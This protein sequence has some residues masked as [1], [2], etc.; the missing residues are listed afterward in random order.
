MHDEPILKA[1]SANRRYALRNDH[2]DLSAP[3]E[4]GLAVVTCM[5]ARIDPLT[6]MG[7]QLGD[8]HVI[9]NAGSVVTEDVLRSLVVSHH[10]LGTRHVMVIGHTDCGMATFNG[11]DFADE[12]TAASGVRADDIK[13][14][15]TFGHVQSHVRRQV[16]RVLDHPWV[17]EDVKVRG[18][19]FDVHTGWLSEVEATPAPQEPAL[20]SVN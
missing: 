14:F 1:L 4:E 19:V 8:A 17:P 20:A 7:L 16:C 12:L 13:S 15:H 9:R 3:P 11:H 18:F 6:A 10:K 5:D 2:P